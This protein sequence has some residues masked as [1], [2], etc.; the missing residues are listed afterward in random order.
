MTAET[1][2]G[3]KNEYLSYSRLSRYVECPM[4]FYRQ[5]VLGEKTTPNDSLRFGSLMHE[6]L[7][8]FY[9]ALAAEKYVGVMSKERALAVFE[10]KW[11]S[12]GL[13]DP[14][15]FEDGRA[16]LR[17]YLAAN[18][19]FDHS[20]LL[21]V[22]KKFRIPVG[23]FE[24]LGYIDR[25]DRVDDSTIR[26]V[27]YKTNRLIFSREEVDSDLQLSVYQLAAR[28]LFPEFPNVELEFHMLRHGVRIKT[29]RTDEQ[30]EDARAFIETV[31]RQIESATQWPANLG[32]NCVYCDVS[33]ECPA[34]H[35]ALL[36]EVDFLCRDESDIDAVAREREEVAA[37][38]KI[39]YARKSHL[40]TILKARIEH[41]GSFDSNGVHYSVYPVKSLTYPAEETIVFLSENIGLSEG[42]LRSRLLA[43]DNKQLETVLKSIRKDMPAARFRLLQTE[44]ESLAEQSVSSRFSAR[45]VKGASVSEVE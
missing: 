26:I 23:S 5:Y 36:G 32:P 4:S 19:E 22:E 20:T 2:R 30:I 40:E 6:T 38:A 18:P 35:R 43:V 24:V 11:A 9:K 1:V 12:S 27:D 33:S 8:A 29:S 13:T 45:K 10:E 15:L 42:D 34:F 31:G 7:E 3:F 28:E 21:A 25:I 14:K 17:N 44:L 16:I 39:L 41:E 37:K